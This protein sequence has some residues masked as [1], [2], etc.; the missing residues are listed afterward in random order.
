MATETL[1]ELSIG[2]GQ[3]TG[4]SVGVTC[5]ITVNNH[6]CDLRSAKRNWKKK[7]ENIWLLTKQGILGQFR[8]QRREN[9]R[10][11][12]E[13]ERLARETLSLL[14]EN[15]QL[16]NEKE[17]LVRGKEQ[18]VEING[19]LR[20]NLQKA[21]QNESSL[22]ERERELDGKAARLKKREKLYQREQEVD[23]RARR[24]ESDKLNIRHKR[25]RYKLKDARMQCENLQ[26]RANSLQDKYDHLLKIP[27][28]ETGSRP[29]EAEW[30]LHQAY[31]SSPRPWPGEPQRP[32]EQV[33]DWQSRGKDGRR[34]LPDVPGQVLSP[35]DRATTYHT[36]ERLDGRGL[37]T[38]KRT[39]I[40][41]PAKK[42]NRPELDKLY[43]QLSS[44]P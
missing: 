15:R 39:R 6:S 13:N 3:A 10:L 16:V 44:D 1:P 32:I 25:D 33:E 31:A 37:G 24:A 5:P 28:S 7:A 42:R 26:R 29:M 27:V 9:G 20:A 12:R 34:D 2:G 4:G 43:S 18:L 8:D 23:D 19:I 17:E 41:R 38:S 30:G 14:N 11:V 35:R 21:S 36:R 22:A 40:K